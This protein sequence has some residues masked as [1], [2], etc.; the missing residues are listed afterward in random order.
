MNGPCGTHSLLAFWRLLRGRAPPERLPH[1]ADLLKEAGIGE[2]PRLRM[3]AKP[4]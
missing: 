3:R 4:C 2:A 1:V